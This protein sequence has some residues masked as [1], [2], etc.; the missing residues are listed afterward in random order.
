[1]E[2]S[3]KGKGRE[4]DFEITE[5]SVKRN[6]R[7][8]RTLTV[9][10]KER[11]ERNLTFSSVHRNTLIPLNRNPLI[12]KKNTIEKI[13]ASYC[14]PLKKPQK[15]FEV[16]FNSS[17]NHIAFSPIQPL[18]ITEIEEKLDLK[19]LKIRES[20]SKQIKFERFKNSKKYLEVVSE[21]AR[22]K[23]L[24]MEERNTI[25]EF[26]HDP[27]KYLPRDPEE[28]HSDEE[29]FSYSF[30]NKPGKIR[31]INSKL[32]D[33]SRHPDYLGASNYMSMRSQVQYRPIF[34][35]PKVK[36]DNDSLVQEAF[37]VK[38]CLAKR[39]I[40]CSFR[41]I[42]GNVYDPVYSSG[43]PKGGEGLLSK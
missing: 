32:L 14:S 37:R 36:K 42:L 23:N 43:F 4:T 15:A 28:Y 17:K 19:L 5:G 21:W 26:S 2:L 29:D 40:Q 38:S 10:V 20:E 33:I 27:Q 9:K 31:K 41:E 22:E 3:V 1:M 12:S 16:S 30:L 35:S 39:K 6:N 13:Q 11:N 8:H 18:N 34:K 24:R 7:E 25:R